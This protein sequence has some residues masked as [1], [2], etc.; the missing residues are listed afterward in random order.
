[1]TGTILP[2]GVG[3]TDEVNSRRR[4]AL[5]PEDT[6]RRVASGLG[7]ADAEDLLDWLANHRC[8]PAEVSLS[9]TGFTVKFRLP[10]R[11]DSASPL[12]RRSALARERASGSADGT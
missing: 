8:A 9:E 3:V 12:T 4:L 10:L 5:P 11:P 2:A 1:M 6:G 7:R